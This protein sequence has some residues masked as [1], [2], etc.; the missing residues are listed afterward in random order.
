M[1][2][3]EA[4]R[5]LPPIMQ[6][7]FRQNPVA[8]AEWNRMSL[9]HRRAQLFSIFYYRTPESRTRRIAKCVE[10]LLGA[11]KKGSSGEEF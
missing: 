1:E 9:S 11:G 4:E 8:H 7:A 2:T 5:E 10:D 3:I 6:I